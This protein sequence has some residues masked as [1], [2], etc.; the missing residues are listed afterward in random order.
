MTI[1]IP[2]VAERSNAESRPIY[3]KVAIITLIMTT[4]C[5]SLTG[6]M[7]FANRDISESFLFQ[8]ASAFIFAGL[9][10]LPIGILVMN[11]VSK[12]IQKLLSGASE[13]AQ[14][15]LTGT[16]MAVVMESAMAATTTI[17]HLGFSNANQFTTH[18]SQNFIAALPFGLV[19][20]IFMTLVIKPK[21]QNFMN[22]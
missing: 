16:I 10:A 7:S 22:S 17:N 20:A 1:I 18:W 9:V 11:L 5:G 2:S 3:Q 14:K 6:I 13:L 8:W 12:L 21:L 4:I 19:I 15:L